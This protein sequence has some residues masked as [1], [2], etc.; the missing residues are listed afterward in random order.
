[1]NKRL[2]L[3]NL[4][5]R[6]AGKAV[7]QNVS[8][9]AGAGEVIGLT[10]HNGSGKSSLAMTLLGSEEYEVEQGSAVYEGTDLLKLKIE[11]RARRGVMVAWQNPVSLVGVSILALSRASYEAVHGPVKTMVEFKARVETL[12]KRVGL[13]AEDLGRSVNE[14]FSGGE[15]KR[16]ELFQILLLQPKLVVLDE[17]DSGLDVA[18]RA[19][20]TGV[21]KELQ[22]SGATVIVISHYEEIL[23]ELKVS[24]KWVMQN[25]RLQTR[26]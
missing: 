20:L 11:E 1:M 18:G 24:Q 15:K 5:V 9:E 2:V 3:K 7:V 23:S 10:G 12:L 26:I 22:E 17:I 8:V 4:S 14:G 16:L 6:V 21:I 25:G 13:Q 19:L